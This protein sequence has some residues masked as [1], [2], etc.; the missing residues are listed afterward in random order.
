MSAE[1]E[2]KGKIKYLNNL[3]IKIVETVSHELKIAL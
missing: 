2:Y 3:L 1:D